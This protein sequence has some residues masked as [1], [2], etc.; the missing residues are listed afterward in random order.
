V[1]LSLAEIGWPVLDR[2]RFGDSFAISPHGLGIAIGFLLGARILRREAP[3]RG[4]ALDDVDSMIFWALVG[5][6]IGARLFYVIAHFSEFDGIVDMLAV[7]RGGISLLGGIAGAILINVPAM[8]RHGYRF[9]QVMDPAVIAL[10]FG[11][12]IGRIGDLIIGDHLGKPTRWLLAF[13]YRGGVIA[14]PFHCTQEAIGNTCPSGEFVATLQGGVQEN[15]SRS[16]AALLENGETIMQGIGVHQTALY[17]IISASLLFALLW[18]MNKRDRRQGVLTLTFGLW[19]GCTRL[20]TDFLRID[21]TFF[22]LTGSQWTALTVAVISAAIL[23]FWAVSSRAEHLGGDL[24][25]STLEER[26]G[27][28]PGR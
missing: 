23:A 21:K 20:I 11:I 13:Q 15:I 8:R 24:S 17:D 18:F 25:A 3:K 10:A 6:V 19:Y 12:P 26:E 27:E 7:W 9:F 16:G 2:I 5:T 22:G 1:E 28:T 14:P 4:M